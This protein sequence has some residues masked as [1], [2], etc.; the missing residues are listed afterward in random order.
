MGRELSLSSDGKSQ[1]I[2]IDPS[3]FFTGNIEL[4]LRLSEGSIILAYR[5]TSRAS[6]TGWT[7]V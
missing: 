4:D 1:Y 5:R 7:N 2:L 6:F 3:F